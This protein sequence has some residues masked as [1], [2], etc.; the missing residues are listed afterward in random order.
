MTVPDL[1]PEARTPPRSVRAAAPGPP[2]RWLPLA[3]VTA[4]ILLAAAIVAAAIILSGSMSDNPGTLS[5]TASPSPTAS[6]SAA[7]TSSTCNT[8]EITKPALD[9]IPGLPDGW[10]WNTPNIDTYIAN[11]NAAIAR[12]LD[13]F[14]AKIAAE[15][16]DVSAAAHEYV[17]AKRTEMEK[18]S[19]HT[20]TAADGVP[21]NTALAACTGRAKSAMRYRLNGLAKPS[22]S[23]ATTSPGALDEDFRREQG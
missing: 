16:A 1:P 12:G 2:R 8:W 21:G 3:I 6:V 19:D 7:A 4:T 15:P 5:L 10:D 14:E 9:A 13:L 23:A 22:A 11:R 20:Y 18:L 17:S